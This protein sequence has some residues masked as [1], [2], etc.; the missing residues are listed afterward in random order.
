M[1]PEEAASGIERIRHHAAQHNRRVPSDHFGVIIA[2]CLART[3]EA[4]A[5]EAAPRLPRQRADLRPADYCGLGTPD[6]VCRLIDRYIAVGVSKFVL[7]PTCR[8]ERFFE[9]LDA[10]G[11]EM[12]SQYHRP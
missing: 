4:A 9:H 12:V 11:K 2:Y 6:D 10:L 7:R 5:E 1:T 8:P 3:P